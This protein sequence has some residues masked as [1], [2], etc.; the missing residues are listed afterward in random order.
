MSFSGCRSYLLLL[1]I[2]TRVHD[3]F[4]MHGLPSLHLIDRI[5]ELLEAPRTP[6]LHLIDRI[7]ST[8]EIFKINLRFFLKYPICP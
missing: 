5:L 4:D 2:L 3:L 6:T 7:L 1:F 8:C